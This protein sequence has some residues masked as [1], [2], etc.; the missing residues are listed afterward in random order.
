MRGELSEPTRKVVVSPLVVFRRARSAV[1][2][3]VTAAT[4][5]VSLLGVLPPSAAVFLIPGRGETVPE[6]AADDSSAVATRQAQRSVSSQDDCR[7]RRQ[8]SRLREPL[9]VP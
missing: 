2:C 8:V 1:R 4:F 3:P 5:I 9:P 7:V 6:A